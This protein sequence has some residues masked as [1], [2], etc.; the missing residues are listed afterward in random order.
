MKLAQTY[1]DDE[2]IVVAGCYRKMVY[3]QL[4]LTNLMS[5]N[6]QKLFEVHF[7]WYNEDPA[8]LLVMGCRW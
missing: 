6:Y 1:P 4:Y 2:H 7:I 3:W 5:V 8:C